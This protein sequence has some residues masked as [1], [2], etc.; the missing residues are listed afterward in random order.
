MPFAKNEN[1]VDFAVKVMTNIDP[2][3][4]EEDIDFARILM[5]K[6]KNNVTTYGP[7]LVKFKNIG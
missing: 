3:L 7:I 2:Q 6:D 5:K 1:V 4:S